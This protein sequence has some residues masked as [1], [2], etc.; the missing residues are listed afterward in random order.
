[1]LIR[2]PSDIK[3][4]EITP[5][6]VFLNR[7]AVMGGAAALGLA[8]ALPAT[9]ASLTFAKSN[10]SIRDKQTPQDVATTYN[11]FYEFGWDKSD[12]A[13]YASALTT[14]PWTVKIDGLVD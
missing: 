2:R 5:K 1:M 3:S 8:G 9:A 10:Y 6:E 4:S 12:P 11:N 14:T 13:R 7:R